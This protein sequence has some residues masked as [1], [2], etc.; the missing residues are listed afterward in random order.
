LEE[1]LLEDN[2]LRAKTRKKNFSRPI[3][4]NETEE[5]RAVRIMEDNFTD[6]DYTKIDRSR[7]VDDRTELVDL[8]EKGD[9]I[10][11]EPVIQPQTLQNLPESV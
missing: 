5:E 2:P 9:H 11:K 6:Y 1:L 4:E 10:K 8:C 7:T 3:P